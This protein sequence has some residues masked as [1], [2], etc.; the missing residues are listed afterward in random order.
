MSISS[1]KTGEVGTSLLVGNAFFDPA[2]TW[3]IQR[4]TLTNSTTYDV[5]FSNIPQTYQHLQLRIRARG[6]TA[7][8]TRLGRI[9]NIN[10]GSVTCADHRLEGNGTSAS[11]NANTGLTYVNC[12][13]PSAASAT[14]NVFGVAII[15]IHDYTS[16]TKYKTVRSFAGIDNNDTNGTVELDSGL[17]MTTNALTSFTLTIQTDNFASGSTF[18]LYGFKG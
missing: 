18:A 10:G 11:A 5:T 14:S 1:V 2:A 4:T 7:A 17:I 16:T 15:D 6:T 13:R 12:F 8:Y 3:L 9:Y